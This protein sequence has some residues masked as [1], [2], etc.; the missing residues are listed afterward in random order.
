LIIIITWFGAA[1]VEQV[2]EMEDKEL[3]QVDEMM[4]EL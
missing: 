1:D 2:S 4:S 3:V